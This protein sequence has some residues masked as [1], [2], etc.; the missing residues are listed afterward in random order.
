MTLKIM[1]F[2]ADLFLY[3]H[4]P[5]IHLPVHPLMHQ[6]FVKLWPST[7]VGSEMRLKY[8]FKLKNQR[9]YSTVQR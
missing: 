1:E 5:A 9:Q 4:L 8:E 6:P 2:Q 3:V 7:S